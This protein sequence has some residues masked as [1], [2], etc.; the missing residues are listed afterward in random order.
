MVD[1]PEKPR[2]DDA[3]TR[4]L[5]TPELLAMPCHVEDNRSTLKMVLC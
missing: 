4:D 3:G 2:S 5:C 1:S